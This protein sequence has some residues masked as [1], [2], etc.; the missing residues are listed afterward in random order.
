MLA[1][2]TSPGASQP[3]D[4]M[5]QHIVTVCVIVIHVDCICSM[6][7]LYAPL[8]QNQFAL[9]LNWHWRKSYCAI[10]QGGMLLRALPAP[11]FRRQLGVFV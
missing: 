3:Y 1:G 4:L 5:C 7:F 9:A 10:L 11:L 6:S 8:L 2:G